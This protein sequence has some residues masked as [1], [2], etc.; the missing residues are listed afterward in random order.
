MNLVMCGRH[1]RPHYRHEYRRLDIKDLR[2]SDLLHFDAGTLDVFDDFFVHQARFRRG[3]RIK[4]FLDDPKLQSP[5]EWRSVSLFKRQ[6]FEQK[7]QVSCTP[8]ETTDMV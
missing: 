6:T 8:A 5:V 2:Q 1:F 3:V 4:E 7:F